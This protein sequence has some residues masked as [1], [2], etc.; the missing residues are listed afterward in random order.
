MT[1]TSGRDTPARLPGD[2]KVVSLAYPSEETR[3]TDHVGK[4][5]LI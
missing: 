3:F 4:E 2:Q 1:T 5:A